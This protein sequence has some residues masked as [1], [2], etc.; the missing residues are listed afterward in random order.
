[1][2]QC[3][4]ISKLKMVRYESTMILWGVQCLIVN[5]DHDINVNISYG[6]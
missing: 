2:N 1:M 3:Q 5:G 4:V 6:C